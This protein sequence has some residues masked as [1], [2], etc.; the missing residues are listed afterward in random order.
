MDYTGE[1]VEIDLDKGEIERN[2]PDDAAVRDFLG[3]RGI[4]AHYLLKYLEEGIDALAPENLIAFSP[5]LLTGSDVYSSSRL[6]V[7]SLSPLTGFLGSSNVGGQLGAYM[8]QNGIF[9]LLVKGK[10]D[11][12]VYIWID[13]GEVELRDAEDI[14]GVNTDEARRAIRESTDEDVSVGAIGPAGEKLASMACIMFED[15]HAAGRTG[16]GAIMGSKKVKAIGATPGDRRVGNEVRGDESLRA[17]LDEIRTHPDYEEWAQYDNS[18]SVK[19]VEDLGASSVRN[20]RKVQSEDVEEADGRSFMDLPR[21]PSSCYR[22]P[23]H[24]KAEL[25]LTRGP[26]E[27][28]KAERPCFEPLVALGPKCGNSDSL[29][30]IRL[31]NKCNDL[32]LDSIEA[33]SLIAFAMDLYDRGIISKKDAGG[34]DLEWGNSEAMADLIDMIANGNGW[35]GKTLS[36]GLKSAAE[37]IGQGAEELAFHVKGL[38]MTAMDPRGFKAS[39]LGYAIGNRGSDFTSIYARPEYS[40]SPELAE[41]LFGT[42]KAAD[43]LSEEGK[44]QL[45][46]RASIVSAIV[47]SLGICKV[48]LLS[49]IED[50]DLSVT[51]ELATKVLGKK[52]D[53]EDLL[54]IGERIVT[55]ERLFNVR[56][57]LTGE[58]DRLP[59]KFTSEPISEGPVKGA[60]VDLESMLGEFYSRMGWDEKGIPDREKLKGLGLLELGKSMIEGP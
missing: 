50:Y 58:D 26:N 39:G 60:V 41:E 20:Y 43:R 28:E 46:K 22:C 15:G 33:G 17:Y 29:E 5:G 11:K 53:P 13:R 10:A 52:M 57:G 49:L 36:K 45:V 1:L 56:M 34:L 40:F 23:V 31:H 51:S 38:A 2:R 42:D 4:N 3:G 9:S 21:T 18:T 55:G 35:L 25:E 7:G 32:G 59:E 27:G 6:H 19:W 16:M 48:P 37:E 47:D 44:P 24:C 30:S 12:P 14:W 54:I 8:K